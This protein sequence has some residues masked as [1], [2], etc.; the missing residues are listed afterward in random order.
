MVTHRWS[1][2]GHRD[3]GQDF[4]EDVI[5]KQSPTVARFWG[6][7]HEG[8]TFQAQGE[9]ETV[10]RVHVYSKLYNVDR[11]ARDETAEKTGSNPGALQTPCWKPSTLF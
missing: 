3:I 11:V 2:D 6:W 5:L 10:G 9:V 1:C 4:P 8:E 7:G